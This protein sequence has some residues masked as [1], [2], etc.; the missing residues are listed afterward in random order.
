MKLDIVRAWKDEAYRQSLNEEQ[1]GTL[2]A[3]PAGQLELAD[4][5]LES[6]YGCGGGPIGVPGPIAGPGPVGGGGVVGIVAEHG[7]HHGGEIESFT[8]IACETVIS[9]VNILQQ[10]III[11]SIATTTCVNKD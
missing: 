7:H 4:A 9:S 6:I 5:Q 11:L 3:N 8:L 1:L 2:P 10:L